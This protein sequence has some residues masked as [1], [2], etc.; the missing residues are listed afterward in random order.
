MSKPA[1]LTTTFPVDRSFDR[2]RMHHLGSL[3]LD[4]AGKRVLEVGAGIGELTWFWED[5][6]C[7]VIST[8]VRDLNVNYA[9]LKY[10]HRTVLERDV[11]KKGSHRDLGMF[12]IVFCYGLLYHVPDPGFV[13]ADL[14]ELCTEL[15]LVESMVDANDGP[16]QA[17]QR[18]EY[19]GINHGIYNLAC[20]P[21][22]S[23]FMQE[24]SRNFPYVYATKTQPKSQYFPLSWPVPQPHLAR[25]V[26]VASRQELALDSLSTTLLNEQTYWEE[27]DAGKAV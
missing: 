22:R 17:D 2:A 18:Q 1:K 16:P 9:R 23:W 7:E 13:I 10:P 11:T 8:E 26:F 21:T 3:G 24:L 5:L 15:F 4:L 14:G 27:P 12:D 25:S 20:T 6:G 19:I